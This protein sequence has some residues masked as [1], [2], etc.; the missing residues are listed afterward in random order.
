MIMINILLL[1]SLILK[2]VFADD[3]NKFSLKNKHR[4]TSLLASGKLLAQEIISNALIYS[5]ISNDE[6]ILMINE[7]QNYFKLKERIGALENL[8]VDVKADRSV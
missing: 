8:L 1:Q 6:F 7:E 3:E 4:N 5:D 2:S